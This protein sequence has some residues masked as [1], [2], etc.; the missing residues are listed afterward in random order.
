MVSGDRRASYGH[1]F[2][3]YTRT[4]NIFNS[5]TGH[6]LT[7]EDAITFMIC[8]KLSRE[9][10]RHKRDNLVDACGY[11][12]CLDLVIERRNEKP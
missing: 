6:T 10:H 9:R 7:A 1:P 3:D 8:V 5:V 2:D 11:I 12:K 4:A